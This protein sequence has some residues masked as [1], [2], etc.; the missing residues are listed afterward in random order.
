VVAGAAATLVA[1]AAV[2]AGAAE[3]AAAAIAAAGVGA[4]VAGAAFDDDCARSEATTR[5]AETKIKVRETD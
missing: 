5:L 3:G 1:G 4:G 2:A